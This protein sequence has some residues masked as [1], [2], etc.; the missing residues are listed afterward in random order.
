MI[1]I[2]F[3]NIKKTYPGEKVALDKLTL[4][5][6]KA[7]ILTI[8]GPLGSGK[9][10]ILKMI[11]G[12]VIA[13]EGDLLIA[14]EN[15][16][17]L[18]LIALRRKIG[19]VVQQVGLFPH[20]NIEKNISYVLKL[21]G[22]SKEKQ[23]ERAEELME[24]IGLGKEILEIYPRELSD[25]QQQRIAIIRALAA[26]PPI[27]LMD[28]PFGAIDE[29]NRKLLQDE[30]LKLQAS[31]EKTIIFVTHDIEEAMK[32]GDRIALVNKG[33]IEQIGSPKEI[34]LKPEN[35]FV[36]DF[37]G[38][39]SFISFMNS[40]TILEVVDK[41]YP[42]IVF[43]GEND[44]I[45]LSTYKEESLKLPVMDMEGKYMGMV[46]SF[47]EDI[48]SKDI[49]YT[50][51]IKPDASIMKAVEIAFRD[52]ISILPVVDDNNKYIGIFSLDRIYK[53]ISTNL[54]MK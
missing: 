17:D 26:D 40:T 38:E 14:G 28:E 43:N 34:F 23:R 42:N 36:K 32:L 45:K 7:E 18:E 37:F 46:S 31:L 33:K 50:R 6:K 8:I 48:G 5:I 44:I 4:D 3:R 15:I 52:G 27:I 13:D 49:E 19:Y 47:K 20:L 25:E 1:N 2:R 16:K 9:T 12:L 39:K 30:L 54:E 10:S 11:N 22:V 24:L 21:S 29:I 41:I 51:P 53:K 35:K